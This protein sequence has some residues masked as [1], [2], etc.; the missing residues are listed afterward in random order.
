MHVVAVC[1]VWQI[2][3]G[4]AVKRKHLLNIGLISTTIQSILRNKRAGNLSRASMPHHWDTN[5]G[6]SGGHFC[7]ASH[8]ATVSMNAVFYHMIVV[9]VHNI[10]KNGGVRGV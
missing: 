3:A 7:I 5:R 2:H 6:E 10:V 9:Q 8:V 1:P 4:Y